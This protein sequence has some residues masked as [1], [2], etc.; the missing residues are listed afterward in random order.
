MYQQSMQN[1][2]H[3]LQGLLLV[4]LLA[5]GLVRPLPGQDNVVPEQA[6]GTDAE[7]DDPHV[8]QYTTQPPGDDWT[9]PEF[10]EQQW[11]SGRGGFGTRG[12]P[13]ARIGTVWESREIW[14]RRWVSLSD[15]P[16]RAALLIHH[17]EDAEVHINGR[18]IVR[19][20]GYTTNYQ[21]MILND[22]QRASLHPG[23]NLIAVHCRQTGG[24]QFIDAQLVNAARLDDAV[25]P[26]G[27]PLV[28]RPT[29]RTEWAKKLEDAAPLPEY[30]RPQLVR[31]KWVNLNGPWQ[32]A[33]RPATDSRPTQWDGKILVPFAIESQLSGVTVPVGL[34][35][36]LWYR[37]E[38]ELSRPNSGRIL[39]HFGAVDWDTAVW[40]NDQE[41]GTH[42]G[43][44]DPFTIDITDALRDQPRQELLVRVWDPTNNGPQP[45]GKQRVNPGGIFYTS[46]T[47]IWQTVWLEPVPDTYIQQVKLTPDIDHSRI[48]VE[49]VANLPLTDL[50]LTAEVSSGD[51]RVAYFEGTQSRFTLDVPAA[52]LWSPDDPFLYD[53][54]IS[55]GNGDSIA[56]YFGMRSI[57]V[58][59][60]DTG[61]DRLA[62]NNTILFQCGPLDQGW[63]P[64]GLYTAPTDDALRYDIEIT[65]RLGFNATRKHVKVE[66]ARWYY[67]CDKLGLLVWQ[68]MPS[69]HATNTPV[70]GP[71]GKVTNEVSQMFVSELSAMVRN[72]YNH[73]SVVI[74]VPFNEGWGQH[75]TNE[76]LRHV[77]QLDPTRLVDGPSGWRDM[78]FGDL[79]DIHRYPGPAV[80]PV[81]D[82]R[83]SVLSEFG[84]VKMA[85]PDHMWN[86]DG[87]GYIQ[88]ESR[89]QL[90]S[91]YNAL[92]DQL[93]PLIPAGLSA[94]I[95]TQ[96]TDV[97][98]EVNGLLTYDRA[99][100][101]VDVEQTA[102]R[103]RALRTVPG[104]RP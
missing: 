100:I 39:L 96:L 52:R 12:T 15:V 72:L 74:W 98:S 23:R 57:S 61:V 55:L 68:D 59:K 65:K 17:D 92:I 48:T 94:A 18:Q 10:D 28:F 4:A 89:E 32:Y 76:I 82:G 79:I 91:S 75:R 13:G 41:V 67:W 45:V 104:R 5:A 19:L 46:V 103:H 53:L 62:L 56:S 88:V 85:V 47:G 93:H 9:S 90:Q 3:C 31:S 8:W 1:W 69:S 95:Y 14:L 83:V 34:E 50:Q 73:P 64:D 26:D 54:M 7:S 30:P 51:R 63:W 2:P 84:G 16:E 27:K 43:G 78:G 44:F 38:I 58:K 66:P 71:E 97:E 25:G 80:H 87:W 22:V 42:R 36:A 99:V 81:V 40:I 20:A 77:K 33:V 49:V 11:R 102:D 29:L 60:D 21:L 24:G 37:R 70:D 101:K 35:N 6:K 86:Q